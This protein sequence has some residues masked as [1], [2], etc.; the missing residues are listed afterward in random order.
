MQTRG[1]KRTAAAPAAQVKAAGE[2]PAKRG[3][4][5]G[6]SGGAAAPRKAA[7]GSRAAAA[8]AAPGG[9]Q[10]YAVRCKRTSRRLSWDPETFVDCYGDEDEEPAQ[11]VED[12]TEAGDGVW[13]HDAAYSKWQHP[14]VAG[15]GP[16]VVSTDG[17]GQ[18]LVL[19]SLEAANERAGEVFAD[20]L[21]HPLDG[22]RPALPRVAKAGRKRR[23]YYEGSEEEEEE[24][25]E[26]S[27]AE[28][29]EIE[30]NQ[31]TSEAE[32]SYATAA[33]EGGAEAGLQDVQRHRAVLLDGRVRYQRKLQYF[34]DPW[35]NNKLKNRVSSRVE[36]EVV[37][38]ARG[39]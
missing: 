2:P 4:T 10:L 29:S 8:Q 33:G 18:L 35:G 30:D 38:V 25:E 27:E 12:C 28:S 32:G 22:F 36:V 14:A 9:P 19:G 21:A 5:P 31:D 34:C 23:H 39:G 13:F 16:Q 15:S 1:S 17:Q 37:T 26:N 7:G 11:E 3:R 20:M 24:E 6:S